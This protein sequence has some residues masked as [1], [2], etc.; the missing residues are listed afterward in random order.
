M[1]KLNCHFLEKLEKSPLFIIFSGKYKKK[2]V[3]VLFDT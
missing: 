3:G 2:I 1:D